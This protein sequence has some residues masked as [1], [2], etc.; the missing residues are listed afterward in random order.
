MHLQFGFKAG[1]SCTEASF[2][3]SEAINH[4][5]ERGEKVFVCFLDVRKAFDTVWIGGL[6]HKLLSESGVQGKMFSAIKSL[7]SDIQCH[8]YFNG[9]T[10]D[11]FPVTQG[12][13]QGRVIVAFMYKVYIS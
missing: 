1:T 12:S 13:G 3:I 5:V 2:L 8:V 11:L 7:Y 4:F 9:T 10:A 6:M